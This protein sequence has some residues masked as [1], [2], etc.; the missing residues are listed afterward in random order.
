MKPSE[1]RIG[2]VINGTMNAN[3]VGQLT[4]TGRIIAQFEE[5]ETALKDYESIPLTEEWLLKFG[6]GLTQIDRIISNY[7][8]QSLS[9]NFYNTEIERGMWLRFYHGNAQIKI[10]YVHQLQNLYFALTGKELKISK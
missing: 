1:L 6:F 4:V 9:L 10:Q 8:I 5:F 2:N 7:S 3:I